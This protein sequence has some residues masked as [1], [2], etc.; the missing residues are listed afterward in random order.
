MEF[1]LNNTIEILERT[2]SVIETLLT[3]LPEEL[4]MNNEGKD[5]WSPFDVIGHLINGEKELWIVRM[6]IILSD[7]KDKTF[8]AFDRFSQLNEN[9]GKMIIQLLDEFKDLRKKNIEIL[10]SKRISDIDLDKNGIHPELGIVT[11]R[12][13]L[14]MWPAHD[15]THLTQIARTMA[16]QHKELIGPWAKY[17]SIMNK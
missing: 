1:S 5:T 3:G 13:L 16:K 17:L 2:P 9:K 11:L 4:V 15:L 7:K 8:V 14:A 12:Q 6:E 10:R